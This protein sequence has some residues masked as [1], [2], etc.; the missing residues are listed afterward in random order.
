MLKGPSF[1][2][3]MYEALRDLDL[4]LLL[5]GCEAV[6]PDTVVALESDPAFIEAFLVGLNHEMTRE[7]HWREYPGDERSTAFRTFW[8]PA[9]LDPRA[10]EQ[11]PPLHEWPA[12][13]TLGSHL[14]TGTGGNAVLL[15]RGGLLDRYPGTTI[16]TTRSPR[17]GAA[18]AERVH[19]RFRGR[20]GTDMTFV[21]FTQ[22]VAEL[23]AG[24]WLVV[25]EQQPTEPRF[26]L[27]A[28]TATGRPLGELRTWEDLTWGDVAA[29]DEALAAITHVPLGGRLRDHRIGAVQWGT[30]SGHMAAVTLQRAFRIAIP[31][32]DLL[33]AP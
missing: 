23:R 2:H 24:R 16:Y 9:G 33:G 12:A 7:L 8:P 32:T 28:A 30:N 21:G 19:P 29:D 6:P 26:G 18:G 17:P 1:P 27:D 5:P 3:P 14:L 20:L 10:R 22:T 15:I 25:F 13:S 11:I 4:D 31:F